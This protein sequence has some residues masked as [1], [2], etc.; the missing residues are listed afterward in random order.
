MAELRNAGFSNRCIA[1]QPTQHHFLHVFSLFISLSLK[2]CN[3]IGAK[4]K[5]SGEGHQYAG[6]DI[7]THRPKF[8]HE[9]QRL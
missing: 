1:V 6:L 2:L 5:E 7:K 9:L 4:I 3:S 8:F